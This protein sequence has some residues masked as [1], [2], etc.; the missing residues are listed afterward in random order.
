[1][2]CIENE[3]TTSFASYA[4]TLTGKY[5][6]QFDAVLTYSESVRILHRND[7]TVLTTG[8]IDQFVSILNELH[9]DNAAIA[10]G[11]LHDLHKFPK[12]MK[13]IKKNYDDEIYN[14]VSEYGRVSILA[15][16]A[17]ENETE[18]N[19]IRLVF[20]TANDFRVIMMLIAN[21][22]V[23]ILNYGLLPE[24]EQ[25][26]QAERVI[27]FYAPLAHRLGFFKFKTA[28]EDIAFKILYPD[29]YDELT[30][31]VSDRRDQL[32]KY[33]E[34]AVAQIGHELERHDIKADL[35]SRT[36]NV[37]SVYRKMTLTGRPFQKI[38][39]LLAIRAIVQSVSDCYKVLAVGQ[40]LYKPILEEFDDYIQ[41]PKANGYRSLHVLLEDSGKRKFELQIRTEEMHKTSE[42]GIAAHW[43]YKEG[44]VQ[45]TAD[46]IFQMFREQATDPEHGIDSKA[47]SKFYQFHEIKSEIFVFTPKGDLKR[48]PR[49]STPIDFAFAV[50][51]DIGIRCSGAKVN[52]H[53]VSF[54][55]ELQNGDSVEVMTAH[56]PVV[57]SDW[58]NYAHTQ[59]AKSEIRRWFRD[60]MRLHSIKLGEEI[61]ART[62]RKKKISEKHDSLAK[63]C[64][65]LNFVTVDDLY[66]AVGSGNVSVHSALQ[67][68]IDNRQKSGN[69]KSTIEEKV[70]S[71]RKHSKGLKV[72]GVDSLMINFGKCCMPLPG[73]PILGYITRGKGVTV[74]RMTCKNIRQL[75]LE[76]EREIT[77]DWELEADKLFPAGLKVSLTRSDS[78]IKNITPIF[79]NRSINL[80]NYQLFRES[81]YDY[82]I[83]VVEIPHVDDLQ[84][85]IKKLNNKKAVSNVIR[86]NY[87]EYKQLLRSAP[88][89]L[90]I[91]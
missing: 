43:N 28:M 18:D 52:G 30:E 32:D 84:G 59:K 34:K 72:G 39:D 53:I 77:V 67:K 36:K 63:M 4:A 51:K 82:C 40:Q 80:L 46:A 62:F 71:K 23:R 73:D 38:Y 57:N 15:R 50:H 61:L 47:F 37:M 69:G 91:K 35:S 70:S 74:H 24:K 2:V 12:L 66:N 64:K 83:L 31:Q 65:S 5:R 21:R 16:Q 75:H 7:N 90:G 41:R 45:S 25:I 42:M 81:G 33:L 22:Y 54:N 29:L 68:L 20:S 55:T 89:V 11:L 3:N 10:A 48:L 1:M 87:S 88:I 8:Q 14:L 49:G 9:L 78:F 79:G 44:N 86:L 60:Q 26:V 19:Y 17:K 6:E 85:V 27:A 56:K 58:S 76:P 13:A